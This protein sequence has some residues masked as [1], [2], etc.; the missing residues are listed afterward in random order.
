MKKLFLNTAIV[1]TVFSLTACVPASTSTT[2]T[3]STSTSTA[4]SSSAGGILGGLLG[5]GSGAVG[6]ILSSLFSTS[7]QQKDLYGTWNYKEPK[8]AFESE[9]LLA[10]AG[11]TVAA[12]TVEQKLSGY[13]AKVGIT[14]GSSTFT[15]N[16]D[17]T[18]S[19]GSRT[20]TL[21]SGKYTFDADKKTI[22]MTG[23]FGMANFTA[24]VGK[25]GSNIYLMFDADMVL[26]GATTIT[27][28]LGKSTISSLLGNYEGMQVGFTLAK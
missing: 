12:A 16:E 21:Y 22:K 14:A 24:S 13:L 17:G 28:L 23:M 2:S 1:V 27:K 20:K 10:K 7:L 25:S 11:G 6:N 18:Y 4:S 5:S 15:F 3:T 19:L 8:V 9:N 26:S